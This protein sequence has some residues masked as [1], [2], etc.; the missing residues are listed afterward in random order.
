M[1]PP[2]TLEE[3]KQNIVDAI[4]GALNAVEILDVVRGWANEVGIRSA[5]HSVNDALDNYRKSQTSYRQAQA[6]EQEAQ[7]AYDRAV[8]EAEWLLSDKFI[9]DGNKT[10]L[11]V[12]TKDDGEVVRKAMTADE[13]RTWIATE[14]RKLPEVREAEV[15]LRK[16]KEATATT[17]D[18]ISHAELRIRAA[19]GDRDAAVAELNLLAAALPRKVNF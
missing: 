17:R 11:I 3:H 6:A 8:S 15:A 4:E 1:T 16:A 10:F 7:D 14:A 9:V 18:E 2:T 12:A 19:G 13:R 5:R